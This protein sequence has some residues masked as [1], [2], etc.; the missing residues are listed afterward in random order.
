MEGRCPH[1][2][3][4]WLEIGIERGGVTGVGEGVE[5]DHMACR[6]FIWYM[7]NSSS[8]LTHM[9]GYALFVVQVQCVGVW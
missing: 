1:A 3:W 7:C 6:K 8:W 5:P 9:F 4:E 2:L